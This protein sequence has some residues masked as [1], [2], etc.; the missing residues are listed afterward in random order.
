[1][2]TED[3]VY[4]I[5]AYDNCVY[6]TGSYKI[7]DKKE[8]AKKSGMI[9]DSALS[10]FKNIYGYTEIEWKKNKVGIPI[11]QINGPYFDLRNQKND[12]TGG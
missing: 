2:T 12:K 6:F 5:S 1:M 9:Y 7:G 10:Q 8:K 4:K 11:K 3:Y